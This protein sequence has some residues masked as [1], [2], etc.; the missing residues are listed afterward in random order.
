MQAPQCFTGLGWCNHLVVARDF[1][2]LFALLGCVRVCVC[3]CVCACNMYS[4]PLLLQDR[5]SL[6]LPLI[7]MGLVPLISGLMSLLLP[8]TKGKSLPDTLHELKNVE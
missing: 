1:A 8:E 7:V 6:G 4:H 2:L 3:V 5:W